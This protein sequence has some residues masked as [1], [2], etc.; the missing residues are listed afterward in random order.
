MK[1]VL[2]GTRQLST[3]RDVLI[4]GCKYLIIHVHVVAV[5]GP[6]ECKCTCCVLFK[7]KIILL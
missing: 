5:N 4:Q 1:N 7:D 6:G 2:Y 3:L